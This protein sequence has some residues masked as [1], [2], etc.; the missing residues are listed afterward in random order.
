MAQENPVLHIGCSPAES[1]AQAFY[2]DELGLFKKAGLQVDV[3]VTKGGAASVTALIA[4][5]IDVTC[6]NTLSL[7]QAVQRDVPLEIL[8]PAAVWDTGFPNGAAIV[9]ANAP[10]KRAKD[11]EGQTV[12]VLSLSGEGQLAMTAFIMKDGGNI[13]TVKFIEVP[14]SAIPEALTRGRIA[15][16][17]LDEPELSAALGQVRTI[18][19]AQDAIANKFALTAWISRSDWIKAN[20]GVARRFVS[21]MFEAGR[22][23]MANPEPAAKILEKRLGFKENKAVVRFA[24]SQDPAL[25][26]VIWDVASRLNMLRPLRAAEHTWN[27]R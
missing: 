21:I 5:V 20:P 3:Q 25:V 10:Y 11:L 1:Q 17:F 9:A 6:T 2:A 16:A 27:G 14:S 13:S 18:G 23:A 15:S 4:G 26:Q 12:G 7:G 8:V 24:T 19:Y 22:W